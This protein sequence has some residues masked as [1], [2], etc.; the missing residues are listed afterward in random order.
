[1]KAN[2]EQIRDFLQTSIVQYTEILKLMEQITQAKISLSV[3]EFSIIGMKILNRQKAATETDKT[4][5]AL[6]PESLSDI[7]IA[8]KNTIRTGLLEQVV[9]LNHAITPKLVDIHSLMNSDLQHLKK[10][11]SAMQG[12]KQSTRKPGRILNNTL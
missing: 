12:Y 4:I 2:R 9:Q 1:M 10:G 3:A 7:T 11:C 5:L 6:L 8:S